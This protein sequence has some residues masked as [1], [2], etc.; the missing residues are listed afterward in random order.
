MAAAVRLEVR[1]AQ[2]ATRYTVRTPPY[3]KS[4]MVY[5][6]EQIAPHKHIN[7]TSRLLTVL[8]CFLPVRIL[9]KINTYAI[10]LQVVASTCN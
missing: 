1:S 4:I 9:D 8:I 7:L 2:P 3:V 10:V 6:A 5:V